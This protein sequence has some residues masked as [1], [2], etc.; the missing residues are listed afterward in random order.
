MSPFSSLLLVCIHS[1]FSTNLLYIGG[2]ISVTNAHHLDFQQRVHPLRHLRS[3]DAI[4]HAFL[5]K[6][7]NSFHLMQMKLEYLHLKGFRNYEC[8]SYLKQP[9]T[10]SSHKIIVAYRTSNHRFAIETGWWLTIVPIPR[11]K[12]LCQLYYE[13]AT[14]NETHFVLECPSY[15][16]SKVRLPSLFQNVVLR[17]L[18]SFF[19]L[20]KLK[21]SLYLTGVSHCTPLL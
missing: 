18:K 1:H 8:V 16:S 19:Q 15:N 6:E 20:D 10:P 9:L 5:A 13:D 21:I 4:K 11:D 2:F 7:L 3:F 14:E 17:N 12:R